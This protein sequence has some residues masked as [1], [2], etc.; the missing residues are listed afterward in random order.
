VGR[1]GILRDF[2]GETELRDGIRREKDN[3]EAIMDSMA[4]N[5]VV[6]GHD[7]RIIRANRAA[8]V[9]AGRD[10][11]GEM[12]HRVFHGH[13]QKC[14]LRGEDCPVKMVFDTA[15]VYR[16]VHSHILSGGKKRFFELVAYPIMNDN[17][18]VRH[19]VEVMH[20]ITD[21]KQYREELELRNRELSSL[22][23][24]SKVLAR[25]IGAGEVFDE[26][27]DKLISL[28][29]VDG[30]GIYLMDEMH[31]DLRLLFH[32]GLSKDFAQSVSIVRM[33][34]DLPGR[35][36][37]SGEGFFSPDLSNDKRAADSALRHSGLR[38][39]ACIPVRGKEKL[40][41]VFFLFS[42]SPKEF[43]PEQMSLLD[44]VSEMIGISFE[45]SRLYEGL[46][47]LYQQNRQRRADEQRNIMSLASMLSSTVE[48]RN[49]LTPSASLMKSVCQADLALV[50]ELMK[51]GSFSVMA[52]S[53]D[54]MENEGM[55]FPSG[56]GSLEQ[57]AIVR[58]E[59]VVLTT[60]A[61]REQFCIDNR[62]T[63]YGNACSVPLFV[64]ERN[65]G[66]ITLYF[67]SA[68]DLP[69]EDLFFLQ[70][71][72]SILAVAIERSRLHELEAI[73]RGMADTILESI[74]D[75]VMT[76]DSSGKVIGTNRA[77]GLVLSCDSASTVGQPL[78][79]LF[80][81]WMDNTEFQYRVNACFEDA[82]S[83]KISRAEGICRAPGGRRVP[84]VVRSAPVY[85]DRRNIAGV[86]FV[87]RDLS[88]EHELEAMKTDFVRSV[89]H[90]FRT[91]LTAIVGMTEMV[92]EGE[93][94]GKRVKEYLSMVL[95]EARRLSDMVALVL[96]AA[97]IER[98]RDMLVETGVDLAAL[99]RST[100][101]SFESLV[102][103]KQASLQVRLD[104]S[105]DTFSGDLEKLRQL[106]YNLVENSLTFSGQG[107]S[108]DV[109]IDRQDGGLRITV[110]DNGWGIEPDDLPQV[111]EKFHRG[112]NALRTK[113]MG[114]G[115]YVAHEVTKMH[116]GTLSIQSELG[117]GTTVTVDLPLRRSG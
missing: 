73:Q 2:R 97:E 64:G 50:L 95:G 8:Q 42:F 51:D 75:G 1:I 72:G 4:D 12:C 94:K 106:L 107:C 109:C 49:V 108:V 96:D 48:L 102:E 90:E 69:E 3:T 31:R 53:G 54:G 86:V 80:G 85:D 15:A 13:D 47:G 66:A 82:L 113:G 25:S 14:F 5:M 111:T 114:L 79:E 16:T 19:A 37:V 6:V 59:P 112:R 34:H 60:L 58:R 88:A 11:T 55:V 100:R 65:I 26:V 29:A 67:R 78:D 74:T 117:K 61:S 83:G 71:I 39:Y 84:L 57:K 93:I 91:P 62:L 22:N 52:S 17:G 89:S 103:K 99:V 44:A 87:L 92:V 9:S 7:F 68:N 30:G 24:M 41:G 20:D 45:N 101:D 110:S 81:C 56:D 32:R 27:L 104:G 10:I 77:V 46:K 40:I 36:G 35:V 38:G 18:S 28:A 63:G 70:T 43:S 76:V 23:E 116:G 98:G 33:G 115:L 21:Q 105:I